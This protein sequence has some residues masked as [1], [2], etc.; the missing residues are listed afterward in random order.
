M[1]CFLQTFHISL[2][3]EDVDTHQYPWVAIFTAVE[4]ETLKIPYCGGALI[5]NLYVLTASAF[6]INLL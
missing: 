2:S 4:S 5:N 3:E 1:W 6:S